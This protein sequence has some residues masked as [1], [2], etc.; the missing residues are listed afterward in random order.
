MATK[1]SKKPSPAPPLHNRDMCA[2]VDALP[3]PQLSNNLLD[4]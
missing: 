4:N 2:F 1:A 3:D